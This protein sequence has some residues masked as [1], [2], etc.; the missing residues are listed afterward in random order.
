[1]RKKQRGCFQCY[2]RVVFVKRDRRGGWENRN[3]AA[4][5]VT[6]G[7]LWR[8]LTPVESFQMDAV[9]AS[10]TDRVARKSVKNHTSDAI[11]RRQLALTSIGGA[12]KQSL[13]AM[14]SWFLSS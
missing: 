4:A 10:A 1:M 6:A 14:R 9:R 13:A 12:F 11:A 8:S 2:N 7:A 3:R 5:A